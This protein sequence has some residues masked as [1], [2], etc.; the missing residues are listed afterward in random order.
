MARTVIRGNGLFPAK[1][2]AL[3]LNDRMDVIHLQNQT[4]IFIGMPWMVQQEG[5]NQM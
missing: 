5:A 2:I 3:N 1:S 4:I